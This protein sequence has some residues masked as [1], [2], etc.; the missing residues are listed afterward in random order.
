MGTGDTRKNYIQ[1]TVITILIAFA[2]FFVITALKNCLSY[3]I[4]NDIMGVHAV[5]ERGQVNQSP[6]VIE[7]G[8]VQPT[9]TGDETTTSPTGTGDETT[10]SPM[11]TGL[12][13]LFIGA[14]SFRK[15][16]DM[17]YVEDNLPGNSFMLCYNGNQP[18]NMDIE[19]SQI[20]SAGV[21]PKTVI[22]EFDPAMISNHADLSD[23]RLLWDIDFDAKRTIWRELRKRDDYTFFMFYDYWVSSNIDYLATYPISYKLI[24]SRYYL[25]GNNG[26]E[27]T[28]KKT[29]AELDALPIKEDAGFND[30]QKSSIDHIIDLC[31]KNHIRLIFAESP[32][33]ITMYSDENYAN[34]HEILYSYLKDQGIPVYIG[35]DLDFDS[36]NPDFYTDLTHMSTE[37]MN[38]YTKKLVN[39]IK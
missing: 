19:L 14:S 12:D 37:G 13:T 15:G 11:G 3:K 28:G 4:P 22:I 36:S 6:T 39:V 27:V 18:M 38:E 34:K 5:I 21:I 24:S 30:L 16:V 33:Y 2:I 29:K 10:T 17:H 7:R 32:N 20:I 23:K 8:Q 35:K 25:G 9:G 31:S 1:K 26:Q